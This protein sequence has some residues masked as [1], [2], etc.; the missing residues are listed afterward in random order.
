MR[1]TF[2][3]PITKKRLSN[4]QNYDPI[5]KV[6][7]FIVVLLVIPVCSVVFFLNDDFTEKLRAFLI[8]EGIFIL[9]IPI[10]PKIDG[11]A[12]LRALKK[13][14]FTT[15]RVELDLK[16]DRIFLGDGQVV[17][18]PRNRMHIVSTEDE[19]YF[20]YALGT[21]HYKKFSLAKDIES[22]E[23]LISFFD[24]HFKR[25]SIKYK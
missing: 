8:I 2:E 14:G 10:M 15:Y 24:V 13:K 4:L 5:Y 25:L 9:F 19:Y 20:Y 1:K 3:N 18:D 6:I 17:L 12:K 16:H 21:N 7:V 11:F 22:I 23:E